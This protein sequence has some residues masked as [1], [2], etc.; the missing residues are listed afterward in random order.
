MA[1]LIFCAF[2]CEMELDYIIASRLLLDPVAKGLR[3]Y[4]L[5]SVNLSEIILAPALHSAALCIRL[6]SILLK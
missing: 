2:Q 4:E 5:I 6:R 3:E 1:R